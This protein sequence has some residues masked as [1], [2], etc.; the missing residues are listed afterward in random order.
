MKK[1]I[2][3]FVIGMLLIGANLYA[4][5]DLIV[6]GKLGVGLTTGTPKV[7]I[8]GINERGLSVNATT[9]TTNV[10]GKM[11][12]SSYSVTMD[13]AT[14]TDELTGQQAS[15]NMMSDFSGTIPGGQAAYY[16]FQVGTPDTT[17][18]TNATEVIGLRYTLNRHYQNMRTYNITNSYGFRSNIEQGGPDNAAINITN[19]YHQYLDDAGVL[20]KVNITNLYGMYIKKMTGGVNNYGLVLNGDGAGADIVFG[21][22][23]NVKLYS[24]AGDLYV[25]DAA[26]NVTLLGPHDPETGEWIFYS[27]NLKT[28]K[29]VRVNME[30]LVKAVENLTGEKFMFESIIEDNTAK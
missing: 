30:H 4:A 18:T 28:G 14:S 26:N 2:I 5:G 7:L 15:L 6:N 19:H 8:T 24:T 27:K 11:L 10:G 22:A 12:G 1:R 3:I 25:K 20:P 9:T 16:I 29:T 13:G 17:G 23:N 21:P